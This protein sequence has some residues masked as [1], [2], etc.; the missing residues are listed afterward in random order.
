MSYQWLRLWVDALGDEK[1]G[2]L[3]FEDRWHF[4]A[5]LLMKRKG[6]LDVNEPHE[7]R[8]RKVG[9]KLGVGDR[10]RDEIRKR[11]IAVRL[12]DEQWQPLAWG[13][14]QFASDTDPTAT[15]RKRRQ[16]KKRGHGSVTRDNRDSHA[17]VT[18]ESRTSPASVPDE[19][20]SSHTPQTQTQTQTTDSE[21]KDQKP[22]RAAAQPECAEFVQ[23]QKIFPRRAG[24]QRWPDA[25]KHCH[26]RLREG[27]TWAEILAGAERYAAFVRA[28]GKERTEHVQQAATFVGTNR[29]FLEEWALPATRGEVAR[30]ANVAASLEWLAQQEVSDAAA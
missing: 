5:I 8:D 23:L 1:L 26:A 19:S 7:L 4:I 2:L 14:R 15:E 11:L 29:G 28:T 18:H 17:L 20:R 30:D 6:M 21:K 13:K 22:D 12:I 16:R 3:A 27:H 9:V 25:R 24:T 10:D